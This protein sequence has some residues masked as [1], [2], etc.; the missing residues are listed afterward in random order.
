MSQHK[1]DFEGLVYQNDF[2]KEL[3]KADTTAP[4]QEPE[5]LTWTEVKTK[6]RKENEKRFEQHLIRKARL[7]AMKGQVRE[8]RRMVKMINRAVAPQAI[9]KGSRSFM[10]KPISLRSITKPRAIAKVLKPPPVKEQVFKVPP[11]QL[12]LPRL[13][14]KTRVV[15]PQVPFREVASVVP[16]SQARISQ[17]PPPLPHPVPVVTHIEAS[18]VDNKSPIYGTFVTPKQINIVRNNKD[19]VQLYHKIEALLKI[20]SPKQ[21]L[22]G[23]GAFPALCA[24]IKGKVASKKMM[25]DLRSKADIL[26]VDKSKPYVHLTRKDLDLFPGLPFIANEE[27]LRAYYYKLSVLCGD[28]RITQKCH[29]LLLKRSPVKEFVDILLTMTPKAY[30]TLTKKAFNDLSLQGAGQSR[31]VVTVAEVGGIPVNV[32]TPT[33]SDFDFIMDQ[34]NEHPMLLDMTMTFIALH[35]SR[36]VLGW[37]A[38]MSKHFNGLAAYKHVNLW[39]SK[40]IVSFLK[41]LKGIE[42]QMMPGGEL[43]E[44][45]VV[46]PESLENS[47]FFDGSSFYSWI[48]G[49]ALPSDEQ[50]NSFK[51][52]WIKTPYDEIRGSSLSH[53]FLDLMSMFSIHGLVKVLNIPFL[54]TAVEALRNQLVVTLRSDKRPGDMVDTFLMKSLKICKDVF[55]RVSRCIKE[56]SFAPLFEK[57]LDHASFI[58]HAEFILYDTILNEDLSKP[59]LAREFQSRVKKGTVPLRFTFQLSPEKK[60]EFLIDL[61][62]DADRLISVTQD[63]LLKQKISQLREKMVASKFAISNNVADGSLRIKPFA[64]FMHGAPGVGKT[65]LAQTIHFSLLRRIGVEAR[66]HNVMRLQNGSNFY[67]KATPETLAVMCNDLDSKPVAAVAGVVDHVDTVLNLIDT[68]FLDMEQAAVEKKG[69]ISASFLTCTYTTNYAEGNLNN[70]AYKPTQ[71]AF[72]RRF[73]F[74]VKMAVKEQF[75]GPGGTVDESKVTFVEGRYLEEVYTFLVYK[76]DGAQH[77]RFC[78]CST[79]GSFIK[80]LGDTFV[81]YYAKERARLFEMKNVTLCKICCRDFIGTSCGCDSVIEFQEG[82]LQWDSD[83]KALVLLAMIGY[84]D[85]TTALY[86][87]LIVCLYNALWQFADVV[88]LAHL[89]P[90]LRSW[91]ISIYFG[92]LGGFRALLIDSLITITPSGMLVWREKTLMRSLFGETAV[93]GMKLGVAVSLVLLLLKSMLGYSSKIPKLHLQ[94][95]SPDGELVLAAPSTSW[96]RVNTEPTRVVSKMPS[97]GVSINDLCVMVSNDIY[98]VKTDRGEVH[99]FVIKSGFLLTVAHALE[100]C[101]Q[102]VVTKGTFSQIVPLVNRHLV[103]PNKDWALVWVPEL[104]P[105]RDFTKYL[106]PEN[107]ICTF[108]KAVLPTTPKRVAPCLIPHIYEKVGAGAK[109]TGGVA[110]KYNEPTESGHCALPI[111]A[112]RGRSLHI[113][114]LH[115]A[116]ESVSGFSLGTTVSLSELNRLIQKGIDELYW[117]AL[118]PAINSLPF[119]LP[120][121]YVLQALPKKSSVA[122]AMTGEDPFY[123]MGTVNPP[124]C[125]STMHSKYEDMWFRP[126][127]VDLEGSLGEMP[128]FNPPVFKGAVVNDKWID[129]YVVNFSKYKNKGGD[130]QVWNAAIDVYLKDV[131][132]CFGRDS[133]RVLSWSDAILGIPSTDVG[134]TNWNSSCGISYPGAKRNFFKI[135]FSDSS[136]EARSDLWEE[137]LTTEEACKSYICPAVALHTLKDEPISLKKSRAFKTRVFNVVSFPFNLNLKKYVSPIVS[138][139]RLNQKYFQSAIGSNI[140]D[141]NTLNDWIAHLRNTDDMYFAGDRSD[142]DVTA[143]TFELLAVVK[144]MMRVSCILDYS[145]EER[146]ILYHLLLSCIYTYRV[147]KNDILAMTFTMPTGFWITILWNTIRNLL[148]FC[149]A[150]VRFRPMSPIRDYFSGFLL[151]DDNINSVRCE[152]FTQNFVALSFQEFGAGLTSSDK[153]SLLADFDCFEKVSFLKRHFRLLDGIWVAPIEEKTL[154][155]MLCVRTRSTLMPMDH[156]CEAITNVLREIWMHGREKF[157]KYL[158]ICLAL[159]DKYHLKSTHLRIKTFDEYFEEYKKG[160]FKTWSEPQEEI[161]PEEPNR[162]VLQALTQIKMSDFNSDLYATQGSETK[163]VVPNS[164]QIIEQDIIHVPVPTVPN[165]EGVETEEMSDVLKRWIRVDVADFSSADFV[166]TSVFSCNPWDDFLASPQIVSALLP[167]YGI[168]GTLE[169]M[170]KPSCPGSCS[171]IYNVSVDCVAGEDEIQ[172]GYT[173]H[174]TQYWKRS[175]EDIHAIMNLEFGNPVV[176]ELPW[177]SNTSHYFRLLS[178][179]PRLWNMDVWCEAPLLST[180][181]ASAT[182]VAEYFVRMKDYK[183]HGLSLQMKAN[184]PLKASEFVSTASRYA[185]QLHPLVGA[186]LSAASTIMDALGYTRESRQEQPT[187]V[188]KSLGSNL[189][190]VDGSD[191]SNMVG[192]FGDCSVGDDYTYCQRSSDEDLMS[193]DS[194]FSRWRPITKFTCSSDQTGSAIIPVSPFYDGVYL[195]SILDLYYAPTVAGVVGMPFTY[196]RGDM[197]YLVRVSSSS[198]V[199]GQLVMMFDPNETVDVSLM[200]ADAMHRLNN[201]VIDLTGSSNTLVTVG[202][203]SNNFTKRVIPMGS[204]TPRNSFTKTGY[205]GVIKFFQVTPVFAPRST[206]VVHVTVFARAKPNMRFYLPS[207][208]FYKSNGSGEISPLNNLVLQMKDVEQPGKSASATLVDTIGEFPLKEALFGE[209]VLSVRALMQKF[210]PYAQFTFAAVDNVYV[211]TLPALPSPPTTTT[212]EFVLWRNFYKC[213]IPFSYTAYYGS[214]FTGVRGGSRFKVSL[215]SPNLDTAAEIPGLKFGVIPICDLTVGL[216]APGIET[217]FNPT[218]NSQVGDLIGFWGDTNLEFTIPQQSGALWEYLNRDQNLPEAPASAINGYIRCF[219]LVLVNANAEDF[220]VTSA[221]FNFFQAMSSDVGCGRYRKAPLLV[222]DS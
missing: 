31:P 113:V 220:P 216:N 63:I 96:T 198:N 70:F 111:L 159:V 39:M 37:I 59:E 222:I 79:V 126:D 182:G 83:W 118:P 81:P 27:L 115:H 125:G 45:E 90:V 6:A 88:G 98:K 203:S 146:N 196:W 181:A 62:A 9:T 57:G 102:I 105:S 112:Q 185:S 218:Y 167:Y 44:E 134:G 147:I 94:A 51:D 213:K 54:S 103:C 106:L 78:E 132:Q 16:R 183:L 179:T 82:S 211:W 155:K 177:V 60:T 23:N 5:D 184:K 42:L 97:D 144:L 194:L 210:C 128:V 150:W 13:N 47:P 40:K 74:K 117:M 34:A 110:C 35:E 136:I 172:P 195:S 43:A 91:F 20:R 68:A 187:Q 89:R 123:V 137:V 139:F 160:Y 80:L 21:I 165:T 168:S 163:V 180:V 186:G 72:W 84:W 142:Y 158:K 200:T 77:I 166:G 209:E 92:R 28:K 52:A 10:E 67:D 58:E 24:A 173:P 161:I 99:G 4:A 130:W 2:S 149:Y 174:N 46:L 61:I 12:F 151:G 36:S 55:N 33:T 120:D 49:V 199:K 175:Y 192:L 32:P 206:Y 153:D 8:D 156:H 7:D 114:A 188:S 208:V 204:T 116:L 26:L 119:V 11:P 162:L 19:T 129:P 124:I 71:H 53:S 152:G 148:Q 18:P 1:E 101:S 65:T 214:F 135:D 109:F 202:Y 157:D 221:M 217:Y 69:K 87:V 29:S 131:D 189:A 56:K 50:F 121:K 3:Q 15:D 164:T 191:G 127:V 48:S 201:V 143:S 95:I 22:V 138:F 176:I 133:C 86:L 212:E 38:I 141:V 108:D 171:G 140:C 122:A 207:N 169:V 100:A 178:V 73:N 93:N 193:F 107:E 76:W 197:E 190:L 154:I 66:N 145:E 30:V 14:E 170:W 75:R 41:R 64:I 215:A 17:A 25:W 85:R 104:F 205:A 219:Q